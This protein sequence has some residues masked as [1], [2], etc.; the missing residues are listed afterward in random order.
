MDD[1][2]GKLIDCFTVVFPD[3]APGE[4]RLASIASV[5]GW[6]SMASINLVAVIEEEFGIQ[7]E[8]EE[9]ADMASFASVLDLLQQ[10]KT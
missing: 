6:D 7:L 3:L 9:L 1:L 4:V 8:I 10:K 5:P 2:E